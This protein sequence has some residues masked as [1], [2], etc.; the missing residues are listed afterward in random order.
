MAVLFLLYRKKKQ[1]KWQAYFL[2]YQ[3]VHQIISKTFIGLHG[4]GENSFSI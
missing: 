2:K 4:T 3:K 1:K